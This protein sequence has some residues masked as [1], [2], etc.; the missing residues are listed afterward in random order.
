[1]NAPLGLFGG[2]FD[3]VHYGHLRLAEEA[4]NQLQLA[5]VRWIPAGQP[6]HR[7]LPQTTPAQ[8]LDM[9]RLAIAGHPGFQLD[10]TEARTDQPS[11][12]VHTLQR[13]RSELGA[14]QSL[15]LLLGADAFLSLTTWHRW[16]ELF[17]LAHLAIA[18][19]PGSSLAPASLPQS[20]AAEYI[21]RHSSSATALIHQPAGRILPF[22]ITPLDIA[23]TRLRQ[24]FNQGGSNRYLL[25]EPVLD[26]ISRNTLYAAPYARKP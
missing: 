3:P 5:A 2:T 15:V 22:T 6:A 24:T 13:L 20:L 16:Q 25:P 17:S 19:R 10:D 1:M 12:T 14:T 4:R 23:A 26:Y 8:R 21:A 18:T 7:P 11:Y 9:V